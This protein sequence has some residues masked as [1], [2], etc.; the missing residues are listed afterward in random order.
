MTLYDYQA[1]FGAADM[2]TEAMSKAQ[3]L[4]KQL[5]YGEGQT[6]QDTC[7]RLAYT[8]V[9]KLRNTVFGEYLV[10]CAD[11]VAQQ[12]A[13]GLQKVCDAAFTTAM[14]EG[15]CFLKPCPQAA[16]V[17]FVVPPY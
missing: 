8:V 14:V 6:G 12:T 1:A 4:W 16:G 2:T 7:Q 17:C 10:T 3:A 13:D 5:Y 9:N 15:E 11:P